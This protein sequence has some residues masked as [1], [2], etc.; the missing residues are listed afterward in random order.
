MPNWSV[1]IILLLGFWTIATRPAWSV[2]PSRRMAQYGHTAW[3]SSEGYFDSSPYTLAQTNDGF[4]WIG[5][6]SGLLRFDGV[7]FTKFISTRGVELPRVAV[8]SLFTDRDGTLWIGTAAGLFRLKDDVLTS[9]KSSPAAV[10]QVIQ[11]DAGTIWVARANMRVP[12]GA[13]CKVVGEELQCLDP[14]H[15]FPLPLAKTL[16]ADHNGNIWVGGATSYIRWSPNSQTVY[17]PDAFKNNN[18]MAAIGAINLAPDGHPLIGMERDGPGLGLEEMFEGKPR[19]YGPFSGFKAED[20]DTGVIRSDSHGAVWIG[21]TK[22]LIRLYKGIADRYDE[23]DG[24]SSRDINDVLEDRE[25]NIW[26]ATAG[27]LDRL[28]DLPIR[29]FD[30]HE[31]LRVPSS[32]SLLAERTGRLW[33]Q[34]GFE[35]SFMDPS[36]P[37]SIRREGALHDRGYVHVMFQ[38]ADGSVWISPG[39]DIVRYNHGKAETIARPPGAPEHTATYAFAED[40]NHDIF[41]LQAQTP[42]LWKI[43]NSTATRVGT[44][45]AL[46]G[47]YTMAIDHQGVFWFAL[48]DGRL[49]RLEGTNLQLLSVQA[50]AE[51]AIIL[52]LSITP[53]N[54]VLGAGNGLILVKEGKTSILGKGAGLPCEHVISF[55]FDHQGDLWMA[56][57]CG[58]IEVKQEEWQKWRSNPSTIVKP[59]VFD[60][61]DGNG[62]AAGPFQHAADVTPDG[63][64]WFANGKGVQM[65][66]P[67]QLAVNR[68]V[69]PVHIQD[70]VADGK[71]VDADS[72]LRLAPLTRQIQIDYTATSLTLPQRVLFRYKLEGHDKDWQAVG[73]RR[74]AFYNDLKPGTYR[75]TVLACNNSGLWNEVGSSLTFTVAPAWFQTRPFIGLVVLLGAVLLYGLYWLRVKQLR[76]RLQ[77]RYETRLEERTRV[78]RD[79]HDTLLQTIQGTK[80]FAEE[81]L[82]EHEDVAQLHGVVE[83]IYEWLSRAVVEGRAALTAL[84]SGSNAGDLEER[85]RVAAEDCSRSKGMTVR[86]EVVGTPAELR[87]NTSEEIFRIGYEA[88][89]NACAHSNGSALEIQLT[90]GKVVKLTVRDNGI[91]FNANE[92]SGRASGHYGIDGMRE[93]AIKL[94]GSLSVRSTPRNGTEVTLSTGIWAETSEWM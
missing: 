48:V 40:P 54:A 45:P 14:A 18:N 87:G 16:A 11:D 12:G 49:G 38:A 94:G 63:R 47:A 28:R 83:K 8:N 44:T 91:G 27:G 23:V 89:R 35:L 9:F 31:G 81:A 77:L 69:P 82:R 67:D 43:H 60:T 62:F 52:Q 74:Q 65:I 86:F 64:V 19:P 51:P 7:R 73:T 84:R 85:L 55:T 24:L 3:R 75:F 61:L 66:E 39:E 5:S 41:A 50:S 78:A 10:R 1:R 13:L 90:Y 58:T 26:V 76:S 37:D 56:T 30:E 53:D 70:V 88:I 46:P 59:L 93:R 33:I 34:D 72:P 92:L 36:V 17:A 42:D 79:L 20:T 57:T 80:L 25:G 22:G 29:A 71:Q 21:S 32:S 6:A 15:G 2:D 4:L 68:I